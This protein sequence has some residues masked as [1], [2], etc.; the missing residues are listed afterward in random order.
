MLCIDYASTMA[1]IDR[2][3][4]SAYPAVKDPRHPVVYRLLRQVSLQRF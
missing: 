2:P 3:P 4:Y 1:L